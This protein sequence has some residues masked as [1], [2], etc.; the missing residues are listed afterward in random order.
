MKTRKTDCPLSAPVSFLLLSGGVG[1]RSAL[2]Y[3]K[4]F[5]DIG[6]RPMIAYSLIAASEIPEVQEIVVNAPEGYEARTR[7]ILT[8]YA[9]GIKAKIVPAGLTRQHSVKLLCDSA[10]YDIAILHEAARPLIQPRWLRDLIDHPAPNA[11]YCAP[12]SFSMC[13]VDHATGRVTGDVPRQN[14]L[15]VQ[16]PQKFDRKTLQLCHARAQLAEAEF[17]EDM[18]LCQA[19]SD[20]EL[21]FIIGCTTNIKATNPE[22]FQ[23]VKL[24]IEQQ[25]KKEKKN[26]PGNQLC[27]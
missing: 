5:F 6:G 25:A 20:A 18:A 7:E 21:F 15:N 12:I 23:I 26:E 27:A 22:D 16:L 14:T 11:G 10:S 17:T 4:Q 2:H 19:M 24:L 8:A 9:P 1:S 13:S 3:P